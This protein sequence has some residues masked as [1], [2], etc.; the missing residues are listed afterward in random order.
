VTQSALGK[1]IG[2]TMV[3]LAALTVLSLL[4]MA[5]RVRKRGRIGR[6]SSALLRSLYP[7]VLG[8]GGWFIGVLI[9]ATTMPGTPLDDQLLAML[10]IGLPI[11]FGVYF[12]WVHRAFPVTRKSAGLALALGGGVLGAWLGFHAAIDML[13]LVTAILG[14]IGGSNLSLVIFDISSKLRTHDPV[15]R[16]L[17]ER[18]DARPS[19]G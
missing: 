10:S 6:K 11:G 19:S 3:G 18:L 5:Y 9:V 15:A 12:A 13:A 8:L 14:A 7:I 2:I 17:P 1:G 4:V 16:S